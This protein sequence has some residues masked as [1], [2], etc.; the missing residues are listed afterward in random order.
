VV[1]PIG[2]FLSPRVRASAQGLFYSAVL[3]ILG[4][5]LNRLNVSITGIERYAGNVYFPTFLEGASTAFVLACG[6]AAFGVITRYFP[7]FPASESHAPD[8]GPAA[9]PTRSPIATPKG[10]LVLL[11][12]GAIFGT[13]AFEGGD[14]ER[15]V[16]RHQ[17]ILSGPRKLSL[18]RRPEL[19]L[20]PDYHF[21][22]AASSPGPVVFSHERH[23]SWN[24]NACT[25]CHF[26]PYAMS[27]IDVATIEC[28]YG[29]M[30]GCGHCHD[31]S[32]SFDIKQGCRLCHQRMGG[33]QVAPKDMALPWRLA[34]GLMAATDREFG[35]VFFSH[36]K[37]VTGVNLA[38][39]EC[40]P[41]IYK[42]RRTDRRDLGSNRDA[43]IEWGHRC[44]SCHDGERAFA[45][46]DRCAACHTRWS[47][48]KTASE[49]D[50]AAGG[51][52]CVA[53]AVPREGAL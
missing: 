9:A 39:S 35:P 31:G 2:L 38:C 4:V 43:F 17:V 46:E 28:E 40:H 50:D 42:M 20:P 33:Q 6:F 30:S 53:P 1:L 21:A 37:H 49:C 27:A 5:V 34:D 36:G 45:Q 24:A 7:V 32:A 11:G 13:V 19:V 3:V 29:R 22:R 52:G 15:A 10:A 41:A 26:R 51:A 18:T 14:T 25:N 16:V 47:R 8:A 23:I 44:K 12:L 48:V